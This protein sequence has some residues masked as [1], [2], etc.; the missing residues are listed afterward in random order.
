MNMDC[1]GHDVT[2]RGGSI[3][4]DHHF[5][6]ARVE[7]LAQKRVRELQKAMPTP[8][9]SDKDGE[10]AIDQLGLEQTSPPRKDTEPSL[11]KFPDTTNNYARGMVRT[12]KTQFFDQLDL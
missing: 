12:P 2:I 4:G 1:L 9:C 10:V 11:L 5:M 7:E 8:K 6:N 3:T